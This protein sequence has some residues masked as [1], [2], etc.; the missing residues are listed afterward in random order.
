MWGAKE[1]RLHLS[2]TLQGTYKL[3]FVKPWVLNIP[4]IKRLRLSQNRKEKIEMERTL[5]DQRVKRAV[6]ALSK[7]TVC[8]SFVLSHK[9]VK[10]NKNYRSIWCIVNLFIKAT[11][12][13]WCWKN[14]WMFHFVSSLCAISIPLQVIN[15]ESYMF[16][17]VFSFSILDISLKETL[18]C[19]NVAEWE[20]SLRSIFI[21]EHIFSIIRGVGIGV[22]S[23]SEPVQWAAYIT[24]GKWRH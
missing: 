8:G 24:L 5:L 20:K 6:N 12:N 16:T 15:P 11:K 22:S 13:T 3:S 1:F 21:E 17:E 14:V 19:E 10:K 7:P 2:I 4:G 9:L 18:F 23:I